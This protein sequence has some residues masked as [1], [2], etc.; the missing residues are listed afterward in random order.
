MLTLVFGTYFVGL[1]GTQ[2][3]QSFVNLQPQDVT[4]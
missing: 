4:L 2:G 3:P 1:L